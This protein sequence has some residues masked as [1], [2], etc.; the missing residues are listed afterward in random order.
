MVNA[1]PES[2]VNLMSDAVALMLNVEYRFGAGDTVH[3][4]GVLGSG[5]EELN[6]A[7][8]STDFFAFGVGG[9]LVQ[10]PGAHPRFS[11]HR[12]LNSCL[13]GTSHAQATRLPSRHLPLTQARNYD[14]QTKLKRFVEIPDLRP[15]GALDI[16]KT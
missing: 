7:R 11:G 8:L 12:S 3:I 16:L 9:K 15:G 6:S 5:D 10:G 2:A 14:R 4:S 13:F 1:N